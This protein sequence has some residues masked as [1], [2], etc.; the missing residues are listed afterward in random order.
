MRY[1]FFFVGFAFLVAFLL[2][3]V[4]LF[5]TDAFLFARLFNSPLGASAIGG[6]VTTV[7]VSSAL[8]R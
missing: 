5:T 3:A 8:R 1:A 4:T 6:G 2:I 7:E